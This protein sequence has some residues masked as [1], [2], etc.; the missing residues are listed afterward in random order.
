MFM[1]KL[2]VILFLF[3][4]G[5]FLFATERLI[6]NN[7]EV[8]DFINSTDILG[9]GTAIFDPAAST[10]TLYNA[11]LTKGA[12]GKGLEYAEFPAILFEG[13]LTILLKGKN[14]IAVGSDSLVMG[15]RL[16]NN[17]IVGSGS[18]TIT[19]DKNDSFEINGMI[20]VP[21]YI[22]KGGTVS[23]A[24]ENNHSK[25]TKWGLYCDNNIEI[26]G[27]SLTVCMSGK[28]SGG[29]LM[30]DK[31]GV[32]TLAQGAALYESNSEPGDLVKT[33]T[34]SKGLSKESKRFVKIVVN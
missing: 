22:Q 6:V 1:K 12:N 24:I 3:W 32:L 8:K 19:G 29:A 14:R 2:S 27:G 21:A 7:I 4:A 25:I 10:L 31:K 5:F 13:D 11:S 16:L 34:W 33:L 18:L 30:M 23:I 17:A 20:Q 15:E 9:D 28:N 26:S